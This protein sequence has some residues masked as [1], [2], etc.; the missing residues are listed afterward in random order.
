M[1]VAFGCYRQLFGGRGGKFSYQLDELA[2]LYASYMRLI[3]YWESVTDG[4]ILRVQY[5]DLVRNQQ[6]VTEQ[7]LQFS[8]LEPQHQCF[9]FYK[10]ERTVKT[11]SASQVRQPM[12]TQGIER[13]K[14]Y[15]TQRQPMLRELEKAGLF[16]S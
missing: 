5:E 14:K 3:D 10:T 11:L 15:Q 2:Q 8:N 7:I 13:W 9:E 1:D 12:F 16:E 6:T 4:L